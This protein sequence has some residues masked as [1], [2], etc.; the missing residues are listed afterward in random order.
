L[1]FV[2][3]HSFW[4]IHL[5]AYTIYFNALRNKKSKFGALEKLGEEGS[6]GK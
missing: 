5:K 3:L 4:Q 2:F 1:R 6:L